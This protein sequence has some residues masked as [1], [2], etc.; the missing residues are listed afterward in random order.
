MRHRS[1]HRDPERQRRQG[2]ADRGAVTKLLEEARRARAELDRGAAERKV[3]DAEQAYRNS[4][5]R[6]QLH[7][8]TAMVY[9]VDRSR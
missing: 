6:S 3:A 1:P 8:F 4:V 2:G 9:G 7:S 5:N